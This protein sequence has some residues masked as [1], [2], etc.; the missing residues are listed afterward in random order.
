MA[1]SE[2]IPLADRPPIDELTYE[3]AFSELEEIVSDLES[4]GQTLDEAVA[5]FERAQA[6]ASYCASLLDQSE[7]RV[8]QLTNEGMKEVKLED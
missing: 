4:D 5:L 7:L 8:Q 1:I 6:L 2:N 3:Q